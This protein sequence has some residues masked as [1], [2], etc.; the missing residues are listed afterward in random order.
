MLGQ[1]QY[2]EEFEV[3]EYD[4]YNTWID[5]SKVPTGTYIVKMT[6]VDKS[7]TAKIVKY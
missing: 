3:S 7:K 6:T 5:L 2:S 4:F 1:L